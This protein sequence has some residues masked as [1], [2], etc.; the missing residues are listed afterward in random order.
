MESALIFGGVAVSLLVEF[1]K[2]KLNL[3]TVQTMLLVVGLSLGGGAAFFFLE[4]YGL[5]PAA[6]QI[7]VSAGAFYAFIIRNLK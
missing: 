5:W 7:V 6:L 4:M 1:I 2:S 3:S